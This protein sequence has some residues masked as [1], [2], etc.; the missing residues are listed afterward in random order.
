M[1][2]LLVHSVLL[3]V[4]VQ[5]GHYIIPGSTPYDGYH[6]LHLHHN[7]P[8]HPTFASVPRT[9]FSCQGRDPGY[10]ADVETGCQAYHICEH[11]SVGSF[12]CTNGTLFN[13]QFQV[14]D[15]FY[16]VRCGSPY[17]DL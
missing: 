12:L 3:Y 15:Q 11:N 5:G 10:Y 2:L 13:E 4:T 6:D 1:K 17:I 9:S 16:N 14:C 7:P 8:L